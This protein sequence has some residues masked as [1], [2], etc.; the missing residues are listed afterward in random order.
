MI[1]QYSIINIPEIVIIINTKS[2]SLKEPIYNTN[3]NH[4]EQ[5]FLFKDKPLVALLFLSNL[6]YGYK[7]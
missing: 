3:I 1:S 2:D 7:A 4:K 5:S 6:K